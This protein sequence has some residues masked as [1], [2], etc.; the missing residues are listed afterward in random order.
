[1]ISGEVPSA[2][3]P[4]PRCS[5]HTR[6]PRAMAVCKT[7]EPAV[8]RNR[9]GSGGGVSSAC[10]G[11]RGFCHV[12]R[13]NLSIAG[14]DDIGLRRIAVAHAVD[15]RRPILNADPQA[16]GVSIAPRMTEN[17][18]RSSTR[19]GVR[20]RQQ[21]YSPTQGK[22]RK[23]REALLAAVC[24]LALLTPAHASEIDCNGY[25]FGMRVRIVVTLDINNEKAPACEI[26]N[27]SRAWSQINEYCNADHI[28]TFRARVARR[29][30]NRYIID[31]I[32]RPVRWGD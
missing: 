25:R 7:E 18:S 12:L 22:D 27:N 23:L 8:A 15:R 5:F 1:V 26:P 19:T 9:G 16:W 29:N 28:C 17:P 6:C 13:H 32:V 14:A 11:T 31:R 3:R 30:G 21:C 2:L 24:F 4:P 20:M 10:G